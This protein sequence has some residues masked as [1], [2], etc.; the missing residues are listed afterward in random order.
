MDRFLSMEV[1]VTAVESGSFTVSAT[2]LKM[3][4]SMIS[5]HISA[6]EKRLGTPLLQRTTRRQ[7]LT[8]AGQAYYEQCK[9]IMVHVAAAEAGVEAMSSH[10]KGMLRVS[11]SVWFGSLTLAPLACDYLKVY[12]EVNLQLSLTDRYVDIVDEGYDVAIRIGNL[13][14]S[15]LIARKLSMFEVAICASPDY[16]QQYGIPQT[17]EDLLQ[18]QCL[19]FSNWHS[20]GGWKQISPYLNISSALRFESDNSQALRVAAVKGLGIILTPR[21]LLK[22]DIEA[23]RLIELLPDYTPTARPIHAVYPRNRQSQPKL[24]TFV[25]YLISA[26]SETA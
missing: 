23:G 4:P 19:G 16:L 11:A 3:T 9:Q 2:L 18:H 25:D 22:A 1:F 7:H 8:E 17:P 13:A 21:A 12:P 10:P 14:D 24:T 20:Q 15:S 5:K 26:F 6:L